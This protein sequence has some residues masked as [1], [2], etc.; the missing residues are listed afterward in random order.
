MTSSGQDDIGL[1][2]WNWVDLVANDSKVRFIIAYR[3]VL[4]KQKNIVY[5]QQLRYFKRHDRKIYPTKAF[6]I[7]IASF[8]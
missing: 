1:D 5:Q 7:D 8:I 2:Q 3:Y 6:T 4:L